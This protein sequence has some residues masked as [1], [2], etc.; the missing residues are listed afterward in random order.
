MNRTWAAVIAVV[1]VAFGGGFLFA[2]GVDGT[3]FHHGAPGEKG[4]SFWSMFGHPRDAGAPRA[5]PT[6]PDGFAIW[7]TRLDTSKPDPLA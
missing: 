1:I 3:L 7:T 4:A 5:G 6:K 2:K